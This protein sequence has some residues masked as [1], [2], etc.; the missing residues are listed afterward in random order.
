MRKSGI[1]RRREDEDGN[2]ADGY[3]E[4]EDSR[5]TPVLVPKGREKDSE[6]SAPKSHKLVDLDEEAEPQQ[7]KDEDGPAVVDQRHYIIIPSY[8]SWFDYNSIHDIEERGVPD[9]FRGNNKSRTPE[10]YM[11]YR[12]FMIDT[13]R[14]NPFEYLSFTA[15][16]RNLSGDI[17]TIARTHSFLEQWGLINYQVDAE[18]RPAPVGP[19]ATSHFMVLADAPN[20]LQPVNP[21]P[22]GFQLTDKAIKAE[23][24]DTQESSTTEKP[25]EFREE[26]EDR[27]EV[28]VKVEKPKRGAFEAGLKTD[29]YA[30]Q[31]AAM[32]LK[33]AAPGRDWDDQETLLLLEALEMYK[34]DWNRVADHVG[35]RTQDECILRLLQLPIQDPF[36]EEDGG[37]VLGPLAYQPTPFSQAANPVMSTVAFLA[38]VVEPRVA[39][40]ACKAALQEY[41]N[42]K[43]ELPPLVLEAHAKNV[44]A[45]AKANNGEVD[46]EV[47]LKESG[48]ASDD[49]T[50]ED[51]NKDE[52]PMETD[53][54]QTEESEVVKE[55]RK[56]VSEKVQTAAASALAAA[57]V[58]ARHLANLEERRMK[59]L[60]AQ[61]VETQMKKLELKL[62]HFDELEAIT[63]RER[64]SFE[65]QRQQLILERQ[66]FHLD[67]LRYMQERSKTDAYQALMEKGELEPGFEVRGCPPQ[68]QPQLL[69]SK[70]NGEALPPRADSKPADA[71]LSDGTSASQAAPQLAGP[72][73]RTSQAQS[74]VQSEPSAGAPSSQLPAQSYGYQYGAA[75]PSGQ[76]YSQ[77]LPQAPQAGHYP[78]QQPQLYYGQGGPP[79]AQRP[80]APPSQQQ[81]NQRMGP[82]Y[83]YNHSQGRPAG[84]PP[85]PQQGQYQ[86]QQGYQGGQYYPQQGGQPPHPPAQ[87]G[88]GQEQAPPQP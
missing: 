85:A 74:R 7:V 49:K 48:I 19:P 67:Q 26:G 31:L 61:L 1:K 76:S 15:C 34:D 87:L 30:K 27:S 39:A 13:Y 9:F 32:K 24:M 21:F 64:E 45:H 50:A 43:D 70:Q 55:A 84:Y 59:S 51:S 35:S 62:K 33:G 52:E 53:E 88:E 37:D 58:K 6:F 82:G 3:P 81:Y 57:A 65:Y 2:T 83:D 38:S 44:D 8:S 63:D 42:M 25:E 46:P 20:G 36:L 80:Y 86:Y 77:A 28:K 10:M 47:G 72:T 69:A 73:E 12:N 66:F 29:Q 40:A 78:P 75:P 54:K 14:L 56:V 23:K 17:C 5:L 18:N 68:M 71:L 41:S 60:V 79:I 22:H 4:D 11:T 16:R